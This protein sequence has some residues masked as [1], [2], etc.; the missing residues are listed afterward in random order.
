M[1]DL[2]GSTKP[3]EL[4]R[5]LAHHETP[6]HLV[7]LQSC[8]CNRQDELCVKEGDTVIARSYSK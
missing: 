5:S 4:P 3:Y 1:F 8:G 6:A 7:L 2:S